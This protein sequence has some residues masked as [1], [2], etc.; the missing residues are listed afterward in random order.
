MRRV[1]ALNPTLRERPCSFILSNFDQR[2]RNSTQWISEPFYTEPQGYKMCLSVNANGSGEGKGTHVSVS[3]HLMKGEFD[4]F[5]EWPFRGTVTIE[6]ESPYDWVRRK[7]VPITFDSYTP[8]EFAG[9]VTSRE[10]SHGWG[11]E[12]FVAHRPDLQ[13]YLDNNCLTFRI[14]SVVISERMC[15]CSLI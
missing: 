2:N 11:C 4:S 10:M 1:S 8:R 13:N 14:R 6:L 7:T 15:K 3:I 5:L 9:Q 12:K